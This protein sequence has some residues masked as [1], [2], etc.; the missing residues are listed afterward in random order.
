MT[1]CQSFH[2]IF[3][4]WGLSFLTSFRKSCKRPNG[5]VTNPSLWARRKPPH[6]WVPTHTARR[7][8][9]YPPT[10]PPR[11][12]EKHLLI[13]MRFSKK[14]YLGINFLKS[15]LP[16]PPTHTPLPTNE[17]SGIYQSFRFT[18][19]VLDG[20]GVKTTED[21]PPII[22]KNRFKKAHF[23]T[24]TSRKNDGGLTLETPSP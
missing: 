15:G 8:S 3:G 20:G 4:G 9:G 10:H 13:W 7:G 14:S 5:D 22:W 2:F 19:H 21:P 12:L 16:T 23:L 1:V 11:I 18:H 17:S 24:S 6:G